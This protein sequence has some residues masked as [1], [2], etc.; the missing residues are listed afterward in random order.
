IVH[1]FS[2]HTFEFVE[3][4]QPIVSSEQI[5]IAKQDSDDAAQH[6]KIVLDDR[7]Q[8][9]PLHFDGDLSAVLETGALDLSE[10]GRSNRSYADLFKNIREFLSQLL[11][12]GLECDL[13]RERGNGVLQFGEFVDVWNRQKIGARAERL[14]DLDECGSEFDQPFAK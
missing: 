10:T 8:I 12:N 11:F 5:R 2:H 14:T 6:G 13:I 1:L 3:H 9:G 7:F 4:T